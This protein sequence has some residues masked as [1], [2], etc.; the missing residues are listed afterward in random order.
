[1]TKPGET[2]NYDALDHVKDII[3]YLKEDCLDYIILSDHDTFSAE[4]VRRSAKKDQYPVKTGDLKKIKK[5]TK[6]KIIMA[7]VAH[8]TE[9][10]RHDSEK[11]KNEIFKMIKK[12][13]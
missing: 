3:K 12:E 1:M 11:I 2:A 4:A 7:D 13:K 9:L 10:I 8:E 6:A 5:I